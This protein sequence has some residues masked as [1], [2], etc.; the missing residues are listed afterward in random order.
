MMV[1]MKVA[2][3]WHRVNGCAAML[4]L[5]TLI[6]D[7]NNFQRMTL[8]EQDDESQKIEE[9]LEQ[10]D[11]LKSRITIPF[12]NQAMCSQE[13]GYMG[14]Q[15]FPENNEPLIKKVCFQEAVESLTKLKMNLLAL[16]NEV[17][18]G[19][20]ADAPLSQLGFV[21]AGCEKSNLELDDVCDGELHSV[22]GGATDNYFEA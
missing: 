7:V 12:A 4:S 9:Y 5:L 18:D 15:P 6:R 8:I 21:L 10:V 14:Y 2:P 1:L 16:K 19:H 22:L 3:Q 17:N 11:Q 20:G 13:L